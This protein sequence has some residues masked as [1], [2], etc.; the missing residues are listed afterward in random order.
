MKDMSWAGEPYSVTNDIAIDH[1]LLRLG[2]HDISEKSNITT[3]YQPNVSNPDT[4]VT[5][6]ANGD[7]SEIVA[8][9][10]NS[11]TNEEIVTFNK[12]LSTLNFI[13]P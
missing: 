5:I 9:Q 8:L 10:A 4:I 7:Y 11:P 2:E 13:E 6:L 1:L 3:V 12:I